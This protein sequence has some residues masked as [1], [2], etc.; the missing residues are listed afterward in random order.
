[1]KSAHF[2]AHLQQFKQIM[3][4]A[5]AGAH[6]HNGHAERAIQT[7]M[8]ISR[9]MMLHAAI[10][11]PEVADS[12]L[13]PMAVT[14]ATY[15]WNHVP[16]SDTGVSP[17]DIFTKTRWPHSRFHDLHVWGCPTYVL[18]KALH[19]GKK[20]PKWKPRSQRMVMMGHSPRH[21]STVP[22]VLNTTTGTI[23]AQF[24]VVFDDW[25]ATV[26]ADPD[27]LPDFTSPEWM[28]MFGESSFQYLPDAEEMAE[29]EA[30][31]LLE[32][33]TAQT[34]AEVVQDAMPPPAP[35]QPAPL[36]PMVPVRAPHPPTLF[37]QPPSG[38]ILP[39]PPALT[40]V[41]TPPSLPL[42]SPPIS[43]PLPSALSVPQRENTDFRGS[44][45]PLRGSNQ[46]VVPQPTAPKITPSSNPTP[47]PKPKPTPIVTTQPKVEPTPPPARRSV[48]IA[49]KKAVTPRKSSRPTKRPSKYSANSVWNTP[50]AD[51]A[52][53]EEVWYALFNEFQIPIPFAL[54]AT[55]PRDPD[56]LTFDE[57]MSDQDLQ[58]WR[59]AAAKEI[60]DL[61]AKDTWEAVPQSEAT[62]RILPGTWVF[63]RKRTP[64]GTV[65]SHKA[66]WCVR[67]DL[68]EGD[69]ETY[70]PVVAYSTVRMFLVLAMMFDWFTCTIDFNNAFVQTVLEEPVWV[71]APRGF[72][73]GPHQDSQQRDTPHCFRLK[74]SLYGLAI[75]PKLFYDNITGAMLDLGFIQ[76]QFDPCLYFQKDIF[77]IFYVDDAGI[78]AKTKA[79]ANN[80]IARM[81]D[82]GFEITP[83]GSF[84]EYLGIKYAKD[85]DGTITLTQPFLIQKILT[86]TGLK[87][88]NPNWTPASTEAL[89]KDPDASSVWEE[90]WNYRSVVGMLLYLSTNTRPDISFAVSQVAR[91][92]NEPK[93]SHAIAVK[94][95]VRYLLRTHEQGTTVKPLP[96]LKLDTFVDADF[97]GL[98]GSDPPEERT[99]AISRTG[100]IIK[101]SNMPLV[102]KSQLQTT[103]TLSTMEAEYSALSASMRVLIPIREM[104][105]EFEKYVDVPAH[106]RSVDSSISTTVHE[107]NNGALMLATEHRITT[108][109][110]H[111]NIKWHH[112]WDHV[113]NGNIQVVRVPTQEQC[114][115]YFTKGLVREVF[116]RCRAM[117]QGW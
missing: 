43:T 114:A 21:A 18:D 98:Y 63:K 9:T 24:H 110:K 102:W 45:A 39:Q 111:Y 25:F 64:D 42:P 40:G 28:K 48:R 107:D 91:F 52:P 94:K 66:R 44:N 31:E 90:T 60:S 12:S 47:A 101:L 41:V 20:I 103:I 92:S 7:I 58:H 75:A 86:A 13:W 19:D 76:S 32:A 22:L 84:T 68:Q 30:A 16:N 78:A 100:Y 23:T 70:A 95:I 74:K 104:L 116:E 57:A 62:T 27:Q 6:H 3:R 8:G 10:H 96:E 65:K 108:R 46:P 97:A 106:F 49:A 37:L 115:D 35:L 5:G 93:K 105:L 15:I 51:V 56:L 77:V 1:M 85:E 82:K 36:A 67:G 59:A 61:E 88:A 71:H 79:I 99:S 87:D 4:F 53:P 81:R 29:H 112:F 113:R 55:G 73:I 33:T 54:A 14:H 11:W 38:S 89:G 83:Q 109:T 80:F 117:N 50:E 34:A 72:H 17:S 26:A 2:P 69:P